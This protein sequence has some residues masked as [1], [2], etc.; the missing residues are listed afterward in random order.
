LAIYQISNSAF[1]GTD[2]IIYT[3]GFWGSLFLY[4]LSINLCRGNNLKDNVTEQSI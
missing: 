3:I 1:K 4:F 2:I